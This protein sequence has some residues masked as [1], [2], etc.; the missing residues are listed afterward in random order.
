MG[1]LLLLVI[2]LF[3]VVAVLRIVASKR[4]GHSNAA[5]SKEKAPPAAIEALLPC[6]HCGVHMIPNELAAHQLSHHHL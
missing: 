1:K 2:V 5:T 4:S 3:A 6:P